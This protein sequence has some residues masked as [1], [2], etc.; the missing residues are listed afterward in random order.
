MSEQLA[1]SRGDAPP[2]P[3]CPVTIQ[4]K[5]KL[6]E[7]ARKK[8][9]TKEQLGTQEAEHR[10]P[11]LN[12]NRDYGEWLAT[13]ATTTQACTTQACTAS[14]SLDIAAVLC[15]LTLCSAVLCTHWSQ[16]GHRGGVPLA[17]R[18]GYWLR[19]TS[20]PNPNNYS[21]LTLPQARLEKLEEKVVKQ[22]SKAWI[23]EH[24]WGDNIGGC[25][26]RV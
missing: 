8:R 3:P 12:P 10:T 22:K 21:F 13:T 4:A 16:H 17:H 5:D 20:T 14:A 25:N 26:R 7:Y 19:P 18:P 1:G 24:P 9:A 6:E 2:C 15:P 23:G 11:S